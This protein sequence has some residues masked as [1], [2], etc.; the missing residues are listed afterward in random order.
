MD[1]GILE[2]GQRLARRAM[3]RVDYQAIYVND[4]LLEGLLWWHE[5]SGD[6]ACLR[7]VLAVMDWRGWKPGRALSWQDQP[8]VCINFNLFLHT[9]DR[10]WINHFV[11]TTNDF[12][13]RVARSFDHSVAYRYRPETGRIFVD[14]V[15][16]YA[17]WMARAGWLSGDTSFFD[18]AAAQYQLFR[19]VLR[20]TKTGLWSQGRGW[21]PSRDFISP[22][23]WLR[24]HGWILRGMVESLTYIPVGHPA[25]ERMRSMLTEFATDLL[26]YQDRRGMWHQVPHRMD[27]YQETTG[28]GFITHYLSRAVAQGLLPEAV[29]RPPAERAAAA[30][31]GFVTRD[32][33]VLSGSAGCGPLLKVEHYLHRDAPPG[34]PHTNG[35]VLMGLSGPSLLAGQKSKMALWRTVLQQ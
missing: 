3:Q 13:A 2:A 6:P 22:L 23:G 29:F 28:T 18:E 15:Q 7:H 4:L 16:G 27:S 20:D 32:G 19:N 21:G 30:L 14:Y 24:G 34:E 11:E 5:V 33:T 9:G 10:A 35:T 1:A 17:L 8:F 12:R 26:R 31:A 25:H